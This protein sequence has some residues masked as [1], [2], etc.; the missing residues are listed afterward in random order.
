MLI[1]QAMLQF[2]AFS[3]YHWP[4]RLEVKLSEED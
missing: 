4:K 2:E 3:G 1:A